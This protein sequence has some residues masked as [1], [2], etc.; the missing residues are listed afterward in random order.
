MYL[1]R[2]EAFAKAGSPL[3]FDNRNFGA[4]DGQPRQG[5][6]SIPGGRSATIGMPSP[7]SRWR[8]TDPQR[9]GIWGSGYS[10]ACMFWLLALIDPAAKC[11]VL[12]GS[13]DQRGW[14]IFAAR[15]SG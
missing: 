5:D 9:I 4:S 8:E 1:D 12:A 15:A 14:R 13:D 6:T 3:V 10:G 7:L 11:I 2:F